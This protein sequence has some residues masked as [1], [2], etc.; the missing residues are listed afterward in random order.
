MTAIEIKTEINKGLEHLP[1]DA[2]GDVL[3]LVKELVKQS[4]EELRRDRNFE[5]II[6][7]NKEVLA[8][9]AK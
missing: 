3:D 9:L 4:E 1:A 7:D 8:R 5:K 2:L 6:A